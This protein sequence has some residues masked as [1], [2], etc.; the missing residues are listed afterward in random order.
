M[1]KF[2][3]LREK[4]R[5]KPKIAIKRKGSK[6]VA[7]IDGEELDSYKSEKD[8]KAAAQRFAKEYS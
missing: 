8:A 7:M 2:T 3:E 4:R 1:I 5:G 6:F